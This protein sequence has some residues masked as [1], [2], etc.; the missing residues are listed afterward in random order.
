MIRAASSVLVLVLAACGVSAVTPPIPPDS[1]LEHIKF[2]AS[3]ELR[4]RSNGSEGL[5]RAA[6]YIAAEF[7]EAGLRPAGDNGTWFQPF[8]LIIG[9]R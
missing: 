9:S 1:I 3:D 7:K 8:P 4:G 2:L 5:E 6:D